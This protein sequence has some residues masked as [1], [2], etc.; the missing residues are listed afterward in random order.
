MKYKIYFSDFITILFFHISFISL[1]YFENYNLLKYGIIVV[2]ALYLI[3]K[4]KIIFQKKYRIV[5]IVLM[6]FCVIVLL[7]GYIN[8]N[9]LQ[10]RN[11]FLAAIVF[12]AI[13]V[14][15]FL[16]FQYFDYINKIKRVISVLY[17]TATFWIIVTDII[18]VLKKD[19]F[20]NSGGYY[21]IGNKFAVGYTHL[22][23]ICLYWC[24][25]VYKQKKMSLFNKSVMICW[26]LLSIGASIYTD[27]ATGLVG[28]TILSLFILFHK[29]ILS[30]MTKPQVALL[31]LIFSCIFL[32]VFD[33]MNSSLVKFILVDILN[34]DLTL[35]GRMNIYIKVFSVLQGHWWSG[36][37]EGSTYEVC[38]ELLGA[39]NTQNG[40]VEALV[41]YG[42]VGL[43]L[44]LVLIACVFGHKEKIKQMNSIPI[45]SMLYVYFILASVE[46]TLELPFFALLAIA[47]VCIR[48]KNENISNY[49]MKKEGAIV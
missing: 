18:M 15:G 9:N 27:M 49:M 24:K 10:E 40:L 29:K 8:R 46:I 47:T 7:T 3:P 31:V 28:I 41:E 21:L 26:W 19:W 35:T 48:M 33:F 14:E 37:G 23:V 5:N 44:L 39:P 38:M 34:R 12:S 30:I 16:I 32:F 4:Y 2:I 20:I 43:V 6:L 36:Y 42:V 25:C 22:L 17:H 45:V 1:P 13:V 11:P